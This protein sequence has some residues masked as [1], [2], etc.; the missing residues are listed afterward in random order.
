MLPE[1]V[2]QISEQI[3]PETTALSLLP[4]WSGF[5]LP[6]TDPSIPALALLQQQDQEDRSS[7]NHFHPGTGKRLFPS[8]L[9]GPTQVR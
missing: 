3:A 2:P 7:L 9:P 1:T 4:R 5:S 8:L 6:R